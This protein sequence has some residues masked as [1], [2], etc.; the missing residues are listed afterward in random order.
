LSHSIPIILHRNWWTIPLWNVFRLRV[1]SILVQILI[2]IC[3]GLHTTKL[4]L[5]ILRILIYLLVKHTSVEPWDETAAGTLSISAIVLRRVANRRCVTW[6][7]WRFWWTTSGICWKL[8]GCSWKKCFNWKYDLFESQWIEIHLLKI[9][10]SSRGWKIL[11]LQKG[12]K[13]VC[14]CYLSINSRIIFMMYNIYLWAH[15]AG[16]CHLASSLQQW[17]FYYISI[18]LCYF[19][20]FVCFSNYLDCLVGIFIITSLLFSF[21]YMVSFLCIIL[22][23]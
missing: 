19:Y 9:I 4:L 23:C 3:V 1:Y 10:F 8:F 21:S 12:T 18:L 20:V 22:I 15:V 13:S 7:D 6:F 11:W 5:L 16:N 2:A 14:K 17:L